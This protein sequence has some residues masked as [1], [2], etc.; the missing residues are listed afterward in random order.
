MAIKIPNDDKKRSRITGLVYWSFTLGCC[1][2]FC[3]TLGEFQT[4]KSYTY[5]RNPISEK[6]PCVIIKKVKNKTIN[7]F[8]NYIR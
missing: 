4:A 8:V 2:D 6:Y 7:I 1:Y 3:V 5:G